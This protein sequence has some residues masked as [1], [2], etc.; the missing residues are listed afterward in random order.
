MFLKNSWVGL[1]IWTFILAHSAYAANEKAQLTTYFP[2]PYGE[3]TNLNSTNDAYFATVLG[4]VGIGCITPVYKLEVKGN[5]A[6]TMPS[7]GYL[8]LSGDLTGYPVNTYPTLKTNY[9]NIYFDAQ[10]T[11][12][13]WFNYSTG[14]NDNSDE[15]LKTNIVTVNNALEKLSQIR[16]VTFQW[17][18]GR[19]GNERHMGVLAQDVEKV[20]PELVSMPPGIGLKSVFYGGLNAMTIEAL[21]E[22]QKELEEQKRQIDLL[23]QEITELKRLKGLKEKTGKV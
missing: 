21:K 4:N 18:D 9:D 3:Y 17:K 15:K 14:F 22:Q 12:T 19:D 16:G 10:G 2:I 11:Y 1:L 13:G 20:A 8:A 6:N 5:I 23:E 7:M